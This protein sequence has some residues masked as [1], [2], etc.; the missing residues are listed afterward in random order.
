[1]VPTRERRSRLSRNSVDPESNAIEA[2]RRI[3]VTPDPGVLRAIGL[4][5]G[6][7]SAVADLID[8]SLDAEATRV[9]VRFVVR[10]ALAVRLLVIDNGRG[11]DEAAID[12]AMRLGKPKVDA[13]SKLG[14]FGMGLKSASFSQASTLTVLSRAAGA[15]SEGRRMYRESRGGDF[16]VDVF[17]PGPVGLRL[18]HDLGHARATGTVVQWDNCRTFPASR[19]PAVTTAFLEAKVAELRHHLGIVFHRLLENHGIEFVV[20]VWDEDEQDAGLGFTVEPL[21]PFAYTRSGASGYPKDL[22]ADFHGQF[23][24]LKCYVWPG[25]SDSPQFRL[26]GRPVEQFQ[27]FYLYRNDRL[28]VTGGWCGVV[29]ETK[30]LKL[31]RVAVDIEAHPDGFSMSMEKS[32]VRLVADMVHAIERSCALDGTTF[33]D[34]LHDAT[35]TFKESNRR[36]RRRTPI[37]PPGQGL[38]PWVKRAIERENTLLQGEEPVRIRWMNMDTDDF[39]ELDR[40]TRTLCINQRYRGAILH[41]D[42]GGVNDAPLLKALLFLLFEDLFRGQAMGA[43][44]KE[45]LHLWNEVLTAAALAEERDSE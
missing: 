32:G 45:N 7:E 6:F 15:A 34:Y 25:N 8:N 16:E 26:H 20:D 3:H 19:D 22:T 44:D 35:E 30:G 1:M 24:A 43:K 41:G 29:H 37:L 11:M 42:H 28:L 21:N 18:D 33:D 17:D 10:G 39:I 9:L 23:I 36:V 27:G 5:H 4:N 40:S 31:A 12:G 13:A 2:V 14:H 38:H